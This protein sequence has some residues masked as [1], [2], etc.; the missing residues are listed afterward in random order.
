MLELTL[1]RA[2]QGY[3]ERPS[4]EVAYNSA[5][6]LLELIGDILDIARIESGR[7][8]LSTERVNLRELANSVVRVFDGLARQKN[9]SLVLIFTPEDNAPD[10]LLDPLR[11]KQ[12]MTNLVSNAIKFTE[13]GQV[14]LELKMLATGVADEVELLL[15][16][17]DTGIGISTF[18][19]ARLFEPF[20]QAENCGQLALSGAGLGLVI[21]RS[22]CQMMGGTLNLNSQPDI[23]TQIH[24]K[25]NVKTLEPCAEAAAQEP[26][27]APAVRQLNVLVVDDHPAN[28]LLMCQQLSYLGHQFTTAHNGAAGLELWTGGA[29]DL[30][31]ADCNM[32]VMNGYDLTRAIRRH[33]HAAQHAPCT[34]LGF[35]ANAQPEERQRCLEA[36][37]NDCLFKP[38]SLTL[39]SQRLTALE[40]LTCAK[41]V[42]NIENL[43]ALSGQD[44][45]RIKLL[46]EELLRTNQ[47]D[48]NT[49]SKLNVN[50]G[51]EPF[52]AIAHR[53]KG[54]ARI[55]GAVQLINQCERLEHASQ[56]TLQDCSLG[57]Q[58]AM[59][60]LEQTLLR[61]LAQRDAAT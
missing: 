37:M 19:Q 27:I 21:C 32:P 3:L 44:D 29:F 30:V 15:N 24:I 34:I 38:I 56:A 10:V 2:D 31:I 33:E 7:L 28:R 48:L 6:D 42:F 26:A 36:G 46:L 52:A 1:K 25:L 43:Y 39:L 16:V 60:T 18:D 22:L 50:D 12:I 8:N 45:K 13:R 17:S 55:V 23:G 47:Q 53:I 11:F 54:A 57:V 59:R 14:T 40:P 61:E 58:H 49:L 41:D 5:K 20:A 4:I 51:Q 9:L 35:T